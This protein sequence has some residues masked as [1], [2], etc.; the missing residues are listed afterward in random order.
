M[1]PAPKKPARRRAAAKPKTGLHERG[2]R[3][4][5]VFGAFGSSTMVEMPATLAA[6]LFGDRPL[7]DCSP[8]GV[9]DAVTRDLAALPENLRTSGLATVALALA[10]ELEHPHNSATSKSMCAGRI[11]DI[12]GVM[13]ALAPP[14][15]KADSIDEI[16]A[17]RDAQRRAGGA[18]A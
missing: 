6:E 8:T 9:V 12:M 5:S 7:G 16:A 18:G 14:E 4:V 17:R 3:V 13:R 1:T 10:R 15:R 11:V 2:A